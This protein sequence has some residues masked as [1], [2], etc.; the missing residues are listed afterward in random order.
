MC[1]L[2]EGE[3]GDASSAG[4]KFGASSRGL[5]PHVALVIVQTMTFEGA[6]SP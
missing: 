1:E 2:T 5:K 4:L 6:V 3:P